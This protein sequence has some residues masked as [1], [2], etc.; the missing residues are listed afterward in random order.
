MGMEDVRHKTWILVGPSSDLD[1]GDVGVRAAE[2]AFKVNCYAGGLKVGE[3]E[4]DFAHGSKD[5]VIADA[6]RWSFWT[7]SNPR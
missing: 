2:L 7:I 3:G 1:G 5:F 4:V 6:E